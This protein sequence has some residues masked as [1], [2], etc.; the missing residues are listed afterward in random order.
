MLLMLLSSCTVTGFKAEACTTNSECREAFGF[1]W[2]C[3]PEVGLCEVAEVHPRCASTWPEDLFLRPENY[4]DAIVLASMFDHSADIAEIQAVRLPVTQVV[5]QGGLDDR[6]YALVQCTYEEN[7]LLDDLDYPGA[8]RDVSLYLADTLGIP[9]IIGPATSGQT[10]EVYNATAHLG[11]FIISPSATSPA[12]TNIDGLIKTDAQPGMLWRTAPPD[13]LQGVAVAQDMKTRGV[14]H[15]AVIYQVGPYGE[16]LAEVFQE[17]FSDDFHTVDGY[18]FDN[19]ASRDSAVSSAGET[20][21]E[22]VF[23]ISSELSDITKFLSGAGVNSNYDDKDFFLAD[24]AADEQMMQQ[25]SQVSEL[26]LRIR[27]SRPAIPDG[28]VYK[29]FDTAYAAAYSVSADIS[30]YTG[31]SFDAAWLAIYGTAWSARAGGP[32]TGVGI[33]QGLRKVSSG[34]EVEIRANSWN[35]VKATFAENRPIDVVG[36]SGELDYDLETEETTTPIEIWT[37]NESG[38]GFDL[39]TTWCWDGQTPELCEGEIDRC[40]Q[41]AE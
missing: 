38:D 7:P 36:A 27:G 25:T 6:D 3:E 12:L 30:V 17:S 41:D 13:S 39:C 4:S 18:L 14:R 20:D 24:G 2:A 35:D 11:V 31:Y 10:Q 26:W 29:A 37:V 21:V 34:V 33:A 32:V 28:N 1:G 16:G 8:A 5:D 40:L 19:D 23:F 22:E 9:A 15:V